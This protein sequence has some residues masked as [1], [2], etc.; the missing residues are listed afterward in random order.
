MRLFFSSLVI[1]CLST[2]LAYAQINQT[3]LF[4]GN[5]NNTSGAN[6]LTPVDYTGQ[7]SGNVFQNDIISNCG[8]SKS[9]YHVVRDAGVQFNGGAGSDYNVGY[10]VTLYFRAPGYTGGYYRL[11]DVKNGVGDAGIYM[12]GSNLN[13]FPNGNV[14]AN[15]LAN[16]ASSY[17]MLTLTR[18]TVTKLVSVYING[19]IA[20]T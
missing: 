17:V 18:N 2:A 19:V 1:F 16:A 13:F 20:T 12:L 10:S 9:I 8:I 6:P 3:Y 4:S 11:L 7:S 5:L 15:L 14:G